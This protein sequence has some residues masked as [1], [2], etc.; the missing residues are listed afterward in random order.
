MNLAGSL[1]Y[2]A[3]LNNSDLEGTNLSGAIF[4]SLPSA[5]IPNAATFAG[6]HL[7][8][9]NLSNAKLSG[10]SF[11]NASFYGTIPA[12]VRTPCAL[13]ANGFTKSCATAAGATLSEADFGG[14][15]LYG[16]DFSS[17]TIQGV[18]F[19]L[20]VLIGAD[21]SG[22]SLSY[23]GLGNESGFD[24]A[25]LQG[26]DLLDAKAL[27]SITLRN[28]Y[29]DFRTGGNSLYMLLDAKYFDYP[30]SPAK[31]TK[32]CVFAFYPAPTTVPTNNTTITCPD[33][34][35]GGLKGCGR[36]SALNRRWASNIA[37][38]Q[39]DPAASYLANATY[40]TYPT[41]PP[42]PICSPAVPW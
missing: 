21:F 15:Y 35:I 4:T 22:A 29:L 25:F 6:A 13:D 42:P 17:A 9:V 18:N 20:A 10:A 32:T 38:S 26:V 11:A 14:A 33:G 16:V 24:S 41:V 5:N 31:G 12:S 3:S 1:F 39:A 37:I 23:G 36:T 19:G 34:I 2:G 8:N 40:T 7:K 30:N 28:A 27:T